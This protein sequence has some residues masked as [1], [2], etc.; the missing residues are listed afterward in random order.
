M[1]VVNIRA[2]N[3]IFLPFCMLLQERDYLPAKRLGMNAL[4]LVRADAPGRESEKADP[5]DIVTSLMEVLP[6]A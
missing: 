2:L 5:G 4:L 3:V 6:R 1:Q